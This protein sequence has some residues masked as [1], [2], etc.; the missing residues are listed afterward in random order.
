M[1][2]AKRLV[3]RIKGQ[4]NLQ[5]KLIKNI[6]ESCGLNVNS[7]SQMTDKK[8]LSSFSLARIADCLNCSTDYLLGRTDTP[9][10][11]NSGMTADEQ[12]LLA[13][14]RQLNADGK[15]KAN[16]YIVDLVKGGVYSD[17]VT[18]DIAAFGGTD[19]ITVSQEQLD[20]AI[21]KLLREQGL[22]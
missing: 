3:E 4:A 14:Y 15:K 21:K 10:M 13:N 1:Y 22:I 20:E 6:L 8:G 16:E 9:A 7:L 12:A 5:N 19:T 17:T 11:E 2:T 18:K